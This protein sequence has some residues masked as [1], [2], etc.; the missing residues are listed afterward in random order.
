MGPCKTCIVRAGCTKDCHEYEIFIKNATEG[1]STLSILSA[2]ISWIIIMFFLGLIDMHDGIISE[3]KRM[4]LVI[5]W[6]IGILFSHIFN[7]KK[8]GNVG[9]FAIILFGPVFALAFLY[10]DLMAR[11]IKSVVRQPRV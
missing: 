6:I 5:I 8:K 2:S 3:A 7:E 11:Y 10:V 4:T 1:V 9:E